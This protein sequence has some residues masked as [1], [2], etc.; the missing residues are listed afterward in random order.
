MA[1]L[2]EFFLA[3]TRNTETDRSYFQGVPDAAFGAVPLSRAEQDAAYLSGA[4]P[5]PARDDEFER[6]GK[7]FVRFIL[8]AG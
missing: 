7:R 3:R 1:R 8:P 4:W 5:E 2:F 6:P